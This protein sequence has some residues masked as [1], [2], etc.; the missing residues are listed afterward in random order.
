MK[1]MPRVPLGS[2]RENLNRRKNPRKL[3]TLLM[4]AASMRMKSSTKTTTAKST[5]ANTRSQPSRR[6]N[7]PR[8][9]LARFPMP[10]NRSRPPSQ[11]GIS[12]NRLRSLRW[13]PN[14]I[15]RC[16][17]KNRNKNRL[18]GNWSLAK[19]MRRPPPMSCLIT[20]SPNLRCSSEAVQF[21]SSVKNETLLKRPKS[22]RKPA[23]S[24]GTMYA[25]SKSKLAQLFHS[26]KLNSLPD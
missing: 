22:S 2:E 26:T 10:R 19:L 5:T 9:K 24:S 18:N 17:G 12:K 7:R 23:R 8:S 21:L 4:T 25:S 11:F 15:S 6:K 13:F 3:K 14:R 20:N 1:M 16:R